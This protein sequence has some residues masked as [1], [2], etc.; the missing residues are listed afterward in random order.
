MIEPHYNIVPEFSPYDV[1]NRESSSD[2]RLCWELSTEILANS[3]HNN[4]FL[5]MRGMYY[6]YV[7]P[8]KEN[9]IHYNY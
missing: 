8:W 7:M 1:S 9:K 3:R 5:K 6:R 4:Y 2:L